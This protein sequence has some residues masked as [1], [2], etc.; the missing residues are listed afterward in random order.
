MRS[1][2]RRPEA[3]ASASSDS[4]SAAKG[5]GSKGKGAGKGVTIVYMDDFPIKISLG[6]PNEFLPKKPTAEEFSPSLEGQM[7]TKAYYG[8][9][10]CPHR[11][12]HLK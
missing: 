4:S 12:S 8:C 9:V 5:Q 10:S 2:R 1:L 7:V 11:I 6:I 3:S